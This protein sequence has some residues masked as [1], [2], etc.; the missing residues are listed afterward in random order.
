MRSDWLSTLL[1]RIVLPMVLGLTLGVV[2]WQ[3]FGIVGVI[4]VLALLFP[5]LVMELRW[6]RRTMRDIEADQERFDEMLRNI[7]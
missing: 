1:L 3:L 2:I 4:V 7:R 6:V 5:W